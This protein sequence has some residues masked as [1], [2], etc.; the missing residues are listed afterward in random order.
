MSYTRTLSQLRQSLL[1]RG[2][3]ERSSDIT[4][5]VANE[6]LNDALEES[7][8]IAVER[9]DD[10]YTL[11]SP[12]F[13]TAPGVGTYALPTDF[14]KHRK[15]EMLAT[16]DASDPQARWRRLFSVDVDDTHLVLQS[17]TAGFKYRPTSAGLVL[18]PVPG[19]SVSTLRVFY[20]PAA[21]QLLLDSDTVQ[22][23]TPVEQKL[24]LHI[25]LRDCYQRQDLP[26][27]E[28]EG[29]IVQLSGQL[30]TAGD[31]DASEPMYLGRR[32]GGVDPY[33]DMY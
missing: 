27:Q 22:F 15:V 1:V 20:I 3:Y 28:I 13:T 14:Y 29:K 25:A 32:G 31:H 9:W 2:G 8:N 6:L 33:G 10:Y 23:D 12:A 18:V 24:V 5:S 19:S 16:G 7:Y 30:R 17:S 11:T 21:P 4:P 26:T